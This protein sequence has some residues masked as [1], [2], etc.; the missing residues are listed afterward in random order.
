MINLFWISY[1][2]LNNLFVVM[3]TYCEFC[4]HKIYKN[5]FFLSITSLKQF[6]PYFVD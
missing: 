2:R 1:L 4:P 6:L 3:G 5:Q